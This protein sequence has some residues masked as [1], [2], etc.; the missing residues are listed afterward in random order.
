[1]VPTEV[2]VTAMAGGF[3]VALTAILATVHVV[4]SRI[5][6]LRT[7]MNERFAGVDGRFNSVESRFDSVDS[8]F[9]SVD[10]RFNSVDS[11]FTALQSRLDD[12]H[13]DLAAVRAALRG[14]WTPDSTRSS[15][16][17]RN[18]G[19]GEGTRQA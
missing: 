7:D 10:S 9:D 12:M 6:D 11:R 15:S 17:D 18:F 14:G 3:A 2:L 13:D 16:A 5:D 4:G 8:R 19:S 1:M